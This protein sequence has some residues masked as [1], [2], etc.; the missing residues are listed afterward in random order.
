MEISNFQIY[1]KDSYKFCAYCEE[2]NIIFKIQNIQYFPA[3]NYE[4][5][6]SFNGL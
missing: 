4:L 2:E 5:T 3:K 6:I 1:S